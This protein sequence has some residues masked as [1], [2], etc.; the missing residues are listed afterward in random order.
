MKRNLQPSENRV[1]IVAAAIVKFTQ[2]TA[3]KCD[4]TY[5]MPYDSQYVVVAIN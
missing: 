5:Y 3:R 4:T 2:D 1:V